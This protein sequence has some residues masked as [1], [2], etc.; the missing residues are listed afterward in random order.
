MSN[1]CEQIRRSM[2]FIDC[3]QSVWCCSVR[4]PIVSLAWMLFTFKMKYSTCSTCVRS[5]LHK[6]MA[7]AS[8]V[9]SVIDWKSTGGVIAFCKQRTIQLLLQQ[10]ASQN[11]LIN[12]AQFEFD[13]VCHF[14]EQHPRLRLDVLVEQQ[15]MNIRHFVAIEILLFAN[16]VQPI[17]ALNRLK[18]HF[19]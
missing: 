2:I 8:A 12:L 7:H 5:E 1:N 13:F 3:S 9:N 18:K 17:V 10:E 4:P 11:Y 15:F 16:F 19:R 14:R 6:F